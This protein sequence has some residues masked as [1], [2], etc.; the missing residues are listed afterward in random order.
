VV[1]HLVRLVGSSTEPVFGDF[2]DRPAEHECR[3][4]T[5]DTYARLGWAP[6]TALN[7]GLKLTVDWYRRNSGIF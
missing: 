7:D 6:K 2:P 3:A 4:N 1:E 5:G